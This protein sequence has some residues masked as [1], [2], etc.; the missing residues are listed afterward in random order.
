MRQILMSKPGEFSFKNKPDYTRGTAIKMLANILRRSVDS[1]SSDAT[2]KVLV[3]SDIS[4]QQVKIK[5]R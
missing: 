5:H 4:K 2:D 1:A 3:V